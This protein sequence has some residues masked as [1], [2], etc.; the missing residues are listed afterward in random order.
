[1]SDVD[2][3]QRSIRNATCSSPGL[4]LDVRTSPLTGRP[5]LHFPY[6]A[7]SDIHWGSRFSRAKRL[8][9]ALRDFESDETKGLGDMFGGIEMEKKATWHLGP[10]HRQGMGL[11]IRK[12]DTSAVTVL[13]GNHEVGLHRRLKTPK[14]IFGIEFRQSST[15]TDPRGRRFLEEHGDRYDLEVFKT[16][17]NQEKWHRIGDKLHHFGGEVDYMLQNGLGFERASV[18]RTGK[19]LFKTVI[20]R[21]MGVLAAMERAIDASGYDGNVSGHSHMMGFHRTPGG[22]LLI[23]DGSCTDHVQFAVH[24]RHGKWGLIEHHRDHMKVEMESGYKYEVFWNA[25]GL[26]H[27]A[28]PPVPVET[29]HTQRADRLLRIAFQMWPAR[30]RRNVSQQI[31]EKDRAVDRLMSILAITGEHRASG[32][33]HWALYSTQKQRS[34]LEALRAGNPIPRHGTVRTLAGRALAT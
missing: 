1:M 21:K 20:N 23:N 2:P 29:V 15:H 4:D 19:R 8:C 32:P 12:A 6:M 30:D 31:E 10:W 18:A 9:M 26:D 27:F 24:D 25:H 34:D 13:S 11:L 16:P 17:E 28:Q 7:I 5:V 14:S 33:L 3:A 22:K